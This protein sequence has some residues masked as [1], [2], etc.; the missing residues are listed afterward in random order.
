M[1]PPLG[2]GNVRRA[3]LRLMV[4]VGLLLAS[5]RAGAS[6]SPD[7]PE[8]AWVRIAA[9]AVALGEYAL[10]ARILLALP[11][12]VQDGPEGLFL[13]GLIDAGEHHYRRAIALF[14]RVLAL[15]PGANRVRL[16]IARSYLAAGDFAAAEVMFQ[17]AEAFGLPFAVQQKVAAALAAI[18]RRKRL[19]GSFAA[20]F[21][22]NSNINAATGAEEVIIGGLP[23]TLS[24]QIRQQSGYGLNLAGAIEERLPLAGAVSL[25][26][27]G[28][29]SFTKYSRPGFDYFFGELF[30]GPRVLFHGGAVSL[31]VTAAKQTYAG[32]P[33][34]TATGLRLQ[35]GIDLGP[36]AALALRANL[37]DE[38]YV[39]AYRA[40]SGPLATLSLVLT[41]ALTP[42]LA[43]RL[44]PELARDNARDP[45]L[46]YTGY[47]LTL[48][49]ARRGLPWGVSA[50]LGI[51][52]RIAQYDG[53]TPLFAVTRLDHE[54][55]ATFSLA[56]RRLAWRG[57]EPVLSYAHTEHLSDIA[58]YRFTRDLVY[59]GLRR[60]F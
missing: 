51:S 20:A 4:L 41:V 22:P 59:L 15:R 9:R 10:A 14:H 1:R 37:A 6:P 19:T 23:F 54:Y 17:R 45:A 26:I 24:R 25:A 8:V 47:G 33:L 39:P 7:A 35:G 57:F 29:A 44:A 40:Y 3:S 38:F 55:G 18:R 32:Q 42:R 21:V 16:E 31:F 13:K 48:S 12:A 34:A 43:L 56:T 50:T 49:L 28:D 36:R 46:R 2:A 53:V 58:I 11:P 27:G 52:Y 30:A 5:A 60:V